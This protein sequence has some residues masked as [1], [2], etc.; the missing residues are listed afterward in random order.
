MNFTNDFAKSKF[1]ASLVAACHDKVAFF[2]EESF[3]TSCNAISDRKG[4]QVLREI[5][6]KISTFDR[7]PYE[8]K[9][10]CT[11]WQRGKTSDHFKGLPIFIN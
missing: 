10:S 3:M 6:E 1:V 5:G 7:T 11:V 4:F 2:E 8:I 9:V